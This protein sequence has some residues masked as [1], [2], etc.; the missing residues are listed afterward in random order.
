MIPPNRR[1]RI[2]CSY[3]WS[4]LI[5]STGPKVR[6]SSK[7]IGATSASALTVG[8]GGLLFLI[9][10]LSPTLKSRKIRE[11]MRHLKQLRGVRGQKNW[12]S[13]PSNSAQHHR[14]FGGVNHLEFENSKPFKMNKTRRKYLRVA[15]E[16]YKLYELLRFEASIQVECIV[17]WVR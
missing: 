17:R 12:N 3:F 4:G 1:S 14:K 10:G 9:L 5:V 2:A 6:K 13:G 11:N 15:C 7:N 8:L 16:S